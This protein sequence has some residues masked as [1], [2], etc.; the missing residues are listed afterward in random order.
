M[1]D[2]NYAQADTSVSDLIPESVHDASLSSLVAPEAVINTS[3]N[4]TSNDKFGMKTTHSVHCRIDTFFNN[5][6]PGAPLEDQSLYIEVNTVHPKNCTHG[7][8]SC[9]SVVEINS[10]A[11]GRFQWNFRSFI[12]KLILVINDWDI[13]CEI[14]LRFLSMDLTY[15]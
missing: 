11:P 3:F 4:A 6:Q 2:S 14:A 7:L 8:H 10:L 12:F 5:K 13:S 15:D 1:F 9:C